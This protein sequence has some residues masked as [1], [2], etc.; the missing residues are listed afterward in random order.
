M[1]EWADKLYE[2][3]DNR[4]AWYDKCKKAAEGLSPDVSA[5]RLLKI[6]KPYLE[7]RAGDAENQNMVGSVRFAEDPLK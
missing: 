7:K 5:D 3:Y 4:V 1:R 2:L 6:L